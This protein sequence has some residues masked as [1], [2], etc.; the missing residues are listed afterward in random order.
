M[1]VV[2]MTH[3]LAAMVCETAMSGTTDVPF[4]VALTNASA[5]TVW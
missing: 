1:F 2:A 5:A 3:A 4:V